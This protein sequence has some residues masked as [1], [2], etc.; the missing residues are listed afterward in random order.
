[1]KQIFLFGEGNK[2]MNELLGGKGANL[3]EMSN[4]GIP[5]PPFFTITT[6]AC[7]AYYEAK[8]KDLFLDEIMQEA[9]PMI[10]AIEKKL[11]RSFGG[12]EE[13]LLFSVRSGA[14]VSMPGMM[15]TVLNIGI[16]DKNLSGLAKAFYTK[17]MENEKSA[18]FALDSYR[19][20]LQMF[21]TTVFDDK[22]AMEKGFKEALASI[23]TGI[24]KDVFSVADTDLDSNQLKELIRAFKEVYVK[25]GLGEVMELC[26][27]NPDPE[28]AA[29]NQLRLAMSAVFKSS[30][31]ARAIAYKKQ[32]GLPLDLGTA[33]NVQAMVFGN[34]GNRS[35]TGVLFTRN[36]ANGEKE[37]DGKRIFYGDWLLNA[38]GEDVVSGI[39][40]TEP[41]ASLEKAMPETYKELSNHVL[42][43]EQHYQDMQDIE[44]TVEEGKLWILQTRS[45]KRTSLATLVCA[46]DMVRET[47][48]TE[49]EAV[50][51]F[52]PEDIEVL[53]HPV[54]DRHVKKRLLSKGLAAGP[55]EVS[56]VIALSP[57][58]AVELKEHGK[59]VILIRPETSPE[60]VHGMLASRGVY[61][62]TGGL[63]SHAA[64]VGKQFNK[65]VIVGDSSLDIEEGPKGKGS[66]CI[67]GT[68]FKEGQDYISISGTTGEI[69]E[70]RIPS[71]E[72]EIE[73]VVKGDIP[74]EK[75]KVFTYFHEIISFAK[76]I[77]FMGVRAN[78][79]TGQDSAVA[80]LFGA[81][82]IGLLRTEHTMFQ[83]AEQ[84]YAMREMIL[85]SD[86]EQRVRA[87]VAV[88]RLQTKNFV[89]VFTAMS[90]L[91]VTVR[92]LDPPLDEFLPN[93]PE[94]IDE[95]VEV[96]KKKYGGE[97]TAITKQVNK[98]IEELREAN[99]MMGFRGNRLAVIYPEIAE[100]QARSI[101]EA[102]VQAKE[103][104][105]EP[106]VEIMAP[107][108]ICQG[109]IEY[110]GKIIKRIKEEYD[111][112]Y[113]N[114]GKVIFGTMIETPRAALT[115]R[116]IAQSVDFMSFGTNDLTQLT[117]GMDRNASGAYVEKYIEE[118]F[119]PGK[120]FVTL[121]MEGP[122]KLL[123]WAVK[124]GRKQHPKLKL[125]ICGEHG[126]D[127][128]SIHFC[129]SVGG[130]G[131]DYVSCGAFKVPIAI[132]TAA[133]AQLENPR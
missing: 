55:G 74:P 35:A 13:P 18:R 5:V 106:F 58:F 95:F 78:A 109:E 77:K 7:K 26:F 87:L 122:G 36:N 91:P 24:N 121:D 59:N 52:R 3:Q 42:K 89:D 12:V 119:L 53:M 116:N 64:I 71:M 2:E 8:D 66:V 54:F 34:R 60:D 117:N 46:V 124:E 88:E 29:A 23:K 94:R 47:L 98:R 84:I 125:G 99:P 50:R 123:E 100:M 132:L 48:I 128:E 57:E 112:R 111:N 30:Q 101:F 115:A 4:L 113:V 83:D 41:I 38:Q 16:C 68:T 65:A 130:I 92:L 104:G 105:A 79:D 9:R 131:L 127:P 31:G 56:G 75:S 15:D 67:G 82:G 37:I 14:K 20:L 33:V 32:S 40:D 96:Y 43:L 39:R 10:E 90:G 107:V 51:R 45:G 86:K 110:T 21:G 25:Q 80:R 73:R 120:P 93:S 63:T 129:H 27:E 118:G 102:M 49:K 81:E 76:N 19:R 126:A 62:K 44:F 22:Q 85:A 114:I 108:T 133:H 28:E 1:M 17:D 97:K 72:S 6:E 103:N 61:T 70:G 69:F 11:G